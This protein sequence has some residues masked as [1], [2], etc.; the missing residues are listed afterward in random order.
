MQ[1]MVKKGIDFEAIRQMTR[2][3]VR[4]VW[5]TNWNTFLYLT[6]VMMV[7]IPEP[8]SLKTDDD[9]VPA[10]NCLIARSLRTL[11][12]HPN[13]MVGLV[14]FKAPCGMHFVIAMRTDIEGRWRR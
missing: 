1:N 2:V 8:S 10:G 6:Y 4:Q 9:Q 5:A 13:S 3:P 12:G 14:D 7:F 11:G